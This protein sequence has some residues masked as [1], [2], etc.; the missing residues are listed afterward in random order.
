MGVALLETLLPSSSR[1]PSA[2]AS[3]RSPKRRVGDFD[4]DDRADFGD[5][6]DFGSSSPPAAELV[7][8]VEMEEGAGGDAAHERFGVGTAALRSATTRR[9][10]ADE[11]RLAVVGETG[12]AAAS[13]PLAARLDAG[14]G[15]DDD[16]K[17]GAG[18]IDGRGGEGGRTGVGAAAAAAGGGGASRSSAGWST[19]TSL[20]MSL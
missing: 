19:D 12:A 16:T 13:L 9:N 20:K 6:G 18:A 17:G 1:S 10:R 5:F 8:D 4:V 2:S 11:R 14:P 7:L 15:G 3:V